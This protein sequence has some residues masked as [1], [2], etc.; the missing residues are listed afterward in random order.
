MARKTQLI[1]LALAVVLLSALPAQARRMT[2]RAAEPGL[3][4]NW[5]AVGCLR[6][7]LSPAPGRAH[8]RAQ[9]G[10]HP[11]F[12]PGSATKAPRDPAPQPPWPP[13]T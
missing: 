10:R 8:S 5:L 7:E 12:G 3:A 1:W 4:R 13:A 11:P 2:S 6:A 9:R